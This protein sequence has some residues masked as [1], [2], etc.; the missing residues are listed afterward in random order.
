MPEPPVSA[1]DECHEKV[2]PC[3]LFTGD[4]FLFFW[5]CSEDCG[6]IGERELIIDEWPFVEDVA[7]GGDIEAAG[8][9]IV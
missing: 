7:T 5:E 3:A 4:A 6:H 2:K 8:F 9:V 1:C